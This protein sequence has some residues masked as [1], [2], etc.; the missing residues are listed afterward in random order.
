MRVAVVGGGIT[1]MSAAYELA[2]RGIPCTLFEKDETLGG[3]AGSFKVNN[4]YLEKF[5][6]HLF[7][8]DTAMVELIHELGL[9]DQFVWND[10][11]TGLYYVQRIYR[12]ATPMD[13]LRFKPLSFPD[14][15]RMGMLAIWPRFIRDW[16][17]LEEIT[18]QEWLLRYAGPRV[19]QVVWEPLLRNKFGH[20]HDQVAAVWI[21]NKL[22]LR[23]GS[24]D[25]RSGAEKLGYQRGGFGPVFIAWEKRMREMGVDIRLN[26]PVEHIRIESGRAVG[27]V[28]AGQFEPFD[29]VIVTTAPAILA[30]MAPDLPEAYRHQLQQIIYLANVCL[31]LKLKRSLSTT[32]WLNIADPTIPFVGLIEHTNMQRPDE[33]GGAHIAY[34]SRYLDADDPYYR[35]SA[36]ELFEAYLPHIRKMFPEF[37]ASWVEEKWAW[38]ERWTQPVIL[39]HYS[40]IRP[41][42][43]T[44]VDNLWLSC[45]ASIYPQDRGMNYALLYGRKVVREMLGEGDAPA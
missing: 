6:H 11:N 13:V 32:Y 45:M 36:E 41:A 3:L 7:T 1:G 43:K 18:A 10:S 38:R 2:K 20:Y 4:T 37:D 19:Y 5:Y 24:R 21:W 40:K 42:L 17:K 23:G 44:P 14:R 26:S 12:L 35:M 39:R 9:G 22:V 31:V 28:A 15:I 16:H 34:L 27:V 30:E 8:T 29:Q 33:Y 25:V